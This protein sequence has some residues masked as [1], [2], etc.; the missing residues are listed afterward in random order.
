MAGGWAWWGNRMLESGDR[1]AATES[2][3]RFVLADAPAEFIAGQIESGAT[4]AEAV[5]AWARE[6]DFEAYRIEAALQAA[7]DAAAAPRELWPN[8]RN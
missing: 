7:F 3:L 5:L 4:L 1:R 8:E 2:E 6:R